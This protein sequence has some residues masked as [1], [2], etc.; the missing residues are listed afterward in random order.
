[1]LG[2]WKGWASN[3]RL[4]RDALSRAGEPRRS[5]Y[6]LM[7]L[8][9]TM[10]SLQKHLAGP[11]RKVEHIVVPWRPGPRSAETVS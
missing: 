9:D 5:P 6:R 10:N 7:L 11:P 8:R 2:K 3:K 1:M 4:H